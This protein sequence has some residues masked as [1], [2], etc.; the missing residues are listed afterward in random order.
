MSTSAIRNYRQVSESLITGGQPSEE[1]L[2]AVAAEG[3]TVVINLATINP[4]YSLPDEEGLTR[5][6]GM[7]Y[8]HIPVAW[9][10]PQESDFVAFEAIMGQ[11]GERKT[12]IHCAANFRV[13]A[14]YALYALKHL[15]WREERADEFIASVWGSSDVPVWQRFIAQ[16]KAVVTAKQDDGVSN[17]ARAPAGPRR[18][19][20][21][22]I[23]EHND[24]IKD[25]AT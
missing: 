3:F 11:L 2:R 25:G 18:A 23:M 17:P 10:N 5:S 12:L 1:Q 16:M 14:F 15:G 22:H 8:Y 24:S 9:D 19:D 6:L 4:R 20:S 21:Q 7:T 13:T